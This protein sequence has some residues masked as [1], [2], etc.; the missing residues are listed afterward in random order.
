MRRIVVMAL[1][2]VL[3][4]GVV[5]LIDG[6]VQ[7]GHKDRLPWIKDMAQGLKAAKE[8]HKPI[9]LD[10]DA[11]WCGWCKKMAAESF[12]DVRVQRQKD[13][14]IWVRLDIDKDPATPAKYGVMGFPTTLVLDPAGAESA[15][16]VGYVPGRAL[17]KFLKQGH[18]HAMK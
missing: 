18:E 11:A 14:F 4:A 16:L 8:S 13:K 12:P 10:F 15:R 1:G 3:L 17:A 9:V 5:L 6:D 7:F 2:A